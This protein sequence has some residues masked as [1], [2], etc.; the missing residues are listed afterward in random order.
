MIIYGDRFWRISYDK[1]V[2]LIQADYKIINMKRARLSNSYTCL[3]EDRAEL[4]K[5]MSKILSYPIHF[6][7]VWN[8]YFRLVASGSMG[9]V[10]EE[11]ICI[12]LPRV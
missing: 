9:T 4:M 1:H 3:A 5:I 6:L 11:I 2:L 7:H 8:P 12:L 10:E